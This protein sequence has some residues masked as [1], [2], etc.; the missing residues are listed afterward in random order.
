MARSKVDT[1]ADGLPGVTGDTLNKRENSVSDPGPFE[2][3]DTLAK[4]PG[5]PE[6]ITYF[7][8]SFWPL[9]VFVN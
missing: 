4:I 1:G 8:L 5:C 3:F 6:F 7:P 9:S 2:A